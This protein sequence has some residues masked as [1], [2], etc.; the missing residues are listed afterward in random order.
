MYL[1]ELFYKKI[2]KV[3]PPYYAKYSLITIV[4]KPM[5]KFINV[6]IIPNIPFSNLR[7]L[8]YRL[9]G[10][11]IGKNVFIGMKCYLDDME[12]HKL[13]IEDDVT[14]S[15]GVYFACHGKNQQHTSIIIKKGSYIGMRS[16]LISGKNGI[17]IGKNSIIGAGSLVNKNVSDNQIVAGVPIKTIRK[18]SYN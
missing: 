10:F 2:L 3:S 16:N 5:R 7:V 4:W 15:Y 17:I 8:L 18:K 11:K 9:I 6:V 13:I 12:P 1:A 14:I